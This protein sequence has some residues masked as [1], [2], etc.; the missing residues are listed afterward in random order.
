M[1]HAELNTRITLV[2]GNSKVIVFMACMGG[3]ALSCISFHVCI[4]LG[5]FCRINSRYRSHGKL[6]RTYLWLLYLYLTMMAVE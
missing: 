6:C 3:R 2:V 5:M 1:A 4:L